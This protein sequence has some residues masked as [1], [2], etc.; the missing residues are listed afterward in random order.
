MQ[1]HAESPVPEVYEARLVA[2]WESHAD[3]GSRWEWPEKT[4]DL[5][6]LSD[7]GTALAESMHDP[8][9]SEFTF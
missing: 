6:G 8:E 4:S 5:T 9:I 7:E 3:V 2:A 1:A